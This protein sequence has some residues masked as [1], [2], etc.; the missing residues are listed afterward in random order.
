MEKVTMWGLLKSDEEQVRNELRAGKTSN[1][2]R[3]ICKKLLSDELGSMLLRYNAAYIGDKSRQIVAD[4][5]TATARDELDLL[6]TGAIEKKTERRKKTTNGAFDLLIAVILC[7]VAALL[8]ERMAVV[9][10]FCMACGILC[11]YVSGRVWFAAPQVSVQATVD[12]DLIWAVMK[13]TAETMD[14]KIEEFSNQEQIRDSHGVLL[15]DGED[16]PLDQAAL[17]LFSDLLE[18]RYV[19]NGDFALRQLSK[20]RP[21]LIKHGVTLINYSED[22]DELFELL[23]TKGKTVTQRPAMVSGKE[24]LIMGKAVVHME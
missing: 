8:I 4:C 21:Y 20:I 15:A 2:S 14:R 12:P 5:I 18:A 23:P 9:S 24:L 13:K 7:V 6:M 3:E 1:R 10:Y 11:A 16:A 19:G 22:K 17:N